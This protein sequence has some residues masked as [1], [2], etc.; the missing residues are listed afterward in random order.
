[1]AQRNT[2]QAAMLA[3]IV[4]FVCALLMGFVFRAPE[5]GASLQP[6]LPPG[7]VSDFIRPVNAYPDLMLRFFA[8]DSLFVISYLIVFI[9]LYVTVV[10]RARVLAAI[11]L[12]A[13]ILTAIFDATENAYFIT[14]ALSALNGIPLVEPDLPALYILA[15]LKWMASFVTLAVFGLI[16]PRADRLGW[17]LAALMLIFPLFGIVSIAWPAGISLRGVFFLIGMPLFAW[18]FYRQARSL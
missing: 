7:P 8:S 15:N 2:F 1:M 3:A 17:V 5:P 16:W 13:G 14:Y 6:S 11:G 12:G 10:H 18:H 9:G 4:A